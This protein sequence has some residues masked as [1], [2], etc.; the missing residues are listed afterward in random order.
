MKVRVAAKAQDRAPLD[1]IK[2]AT[3]LTEQPDSKVALLGLSLMTTFAEAK[4]KNWTISV[5]KDDTKQAWTFTQNEM[6]PQWGA[7]ASVKAKGE[8]RR[9]FEYLKDHM[10]LSSDDGKAV[11]SALSLAGE[12]AKAKKDGATITVE[13]KKGQAWTLDQNEK[14]KVQ[15]V[16]TA[17]VKAPTPMPA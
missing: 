7:K 4:R 3:G 15:A 13:D 9:I 11:L 14:N 17:K 10:Q 16:L 1:Q 8:D 12:F 5:E 6:A 2:Q